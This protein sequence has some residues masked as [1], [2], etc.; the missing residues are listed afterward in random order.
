VDRAHAPVVVGPVRPPNVWSAALLRLRP[1]ARSGEKGVN[2]GQRDTAAP[3]FRTFG[4]R[5]KPLETALSRRR[6]S[7]VCQSHSGAA[8]HTAAASVVA[9]FAPAAAT[10]SGVPRRHTWETRLLTESDPL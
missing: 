6:L 10:L 3:C 5:P 8:T 2:R 9:V 7:A 4:N 1:F